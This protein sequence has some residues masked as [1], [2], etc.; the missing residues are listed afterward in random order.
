MSE[1]KPP[2]ILLPGMGAD[3]RLGPQGLGLVGAWGGRWYKPLLPRAAAGRLRR[4]S[5]A[6]ERTDMGTSE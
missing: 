3:R 2:I 5:H 6:A 4:L 1:N